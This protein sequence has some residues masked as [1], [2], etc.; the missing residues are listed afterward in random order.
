MIECPTIPERRESGVAS[1]RWPLKDGR[2]ALWRTLAVRGAGFPA[3][4]VLKLGDSMCGIAADSVLEAEAEVQ[5]ARSVILE[6]LRRDLKVA[7]GPERRALD[8]IK[9]RVKQN[10]LSELAQVPEGQTWATDLFVASHRL[11]LL[12]KEFRS[13]LNL[14]LEKGSRRDS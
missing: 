3:A 10:Q 2:W 11:E 4:D 13:A 9:R 7:R 8:K 14:A 1:H 5:R 6:R 12:T